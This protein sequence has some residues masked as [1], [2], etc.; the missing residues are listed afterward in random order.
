MSERQTNNHGG[1]SIQY[2]RKVSCPLC[3]NS[4]STSSDAK[5]EMYFAEHKRKCFNEYS[6]GDLRS[7]SQKDKIFISK[8]IETNKKPLITRKMNIDME[9]KG[10]KRILNALNSFEAENT[11]N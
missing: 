5:G 10:C 7:K 11:E 2:S 9:L 8:A 3:G 1:I 6:L 4:Y